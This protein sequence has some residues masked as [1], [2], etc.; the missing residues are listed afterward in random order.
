MLVA[1]GTFL[2][3]ADFSTRREAFHLVCAAR[4]SLLY[5]FYISFI[6]LLYPLGRL[7][8]I[9]L[10][11]RVAGRNLL[12]P[13]RKEISRPPQRKGNKPRGVGHKSEYLADYVI[14]SSAHLSSIGYDQ[15]PASLFSTAHHAAANMRLRSKGMFGPSFCRPSHV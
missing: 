1:L 12:L 5:R 15:P 7:D 9:R 13:L 4:M 6:A 10:K 3:A 14:Y 2:Q 8:C 11:I